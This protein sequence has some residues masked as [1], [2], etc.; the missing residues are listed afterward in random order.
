[1]TECTWL[2][3][4]QWPRTM[5]VR[6]GIASRYEKTVTIYLSGLNPWHLSLVGSLIQT[7]FLGWWVIDPLHR[8]GGPITYE[9]LLVGAS[10]GAEDRDVVEDVRDRLVALGL[11]GVVGALLVLW[12][13]QDGDVLDRD[14]VDQ[15]DEL[16]DVRFDGNAKAELVQAVRDKGALRAHVAVG[17]R[18]AVRVLRRG[19]GGVAECHCW[20]GG[21]SA[22]GEDECCCREPLLDHLVPFGQGNSPGRS[23]F[24]QP[25]S[26]RVRLTMQGSA[27]D[28]PR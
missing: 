1:M 17:A 18:V 27:A 12:C 7:T 14:D 3:T 22:D 21:Y 25:V 15:A 2:A 19:A 26:T 23:A 28:G 13:G 9:T 8:R 11:G 16:L 10:V 5:E 4:T 6:R 24:N 20:R